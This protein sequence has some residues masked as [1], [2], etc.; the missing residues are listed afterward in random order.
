[1]RSSKL[2]GHWDLILACGGCLGEPC[3]EDIGIVLA[4][5]VATG[6]QFW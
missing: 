3:C 1:M 6:Q 4:A 2:G 5:L